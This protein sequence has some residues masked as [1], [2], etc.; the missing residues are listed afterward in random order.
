MNIY[1]LTSEDIINAG[2][3][4]GS[5]TS[6]NYI[7]YFSSKQAAQEYAEKEYGKDIDWENDRSGGCTS[8]DLRYVMYDIK[9]VKI[10]K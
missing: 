9:K 6:T 8:G 2:G 10:T 5:S 7:R 3:H 1:S 4:M